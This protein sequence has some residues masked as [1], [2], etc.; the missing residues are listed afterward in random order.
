MSVETQPSPTGKKRDFALKRHIGLV[1]LTWASMGSI[2]GS[3]WLFAPQEALEVAGPAVLI[4]WV[5][6]GIAIV[7]LALVHAELGGMYPVSGGTARFPH[8]AF[9]GVAGASFGWFAWL[10]AATVAPIEVSAVLTYMGHYGFAEG[11]IDPDTQVLS[12]VGIVVAVILMALMV[13]INLLGV[14]MLAATNSAMT[15]WK[16]AIP[17][18]TILVLSINNF[19][20]SNLHAADGFNPDGLKGILDRGLDGRHHLQLPRLRAGRPARR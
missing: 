18:L 20:T 5:I 12:S 3:G 16:I 17:L 14:R 13:A 8:Y 2:I 10:N 1:G 6:G 11:W 9:G 15:W 7:I 4:S 19:D